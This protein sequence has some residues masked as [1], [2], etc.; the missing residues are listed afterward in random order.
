MRRTYDWEALES[1][2]MA[3]G[4][5]VTLRSLASK[6]GISLVRLSRRA[7]QGKWEFLQAR[8][9]VYMGRPQ[10]TDILERMRR[11]WDEEF[12]K[13]RKKLAAAQEREAEHES[14]N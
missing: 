4:D 9:R 2:Y 12:D 1:E 8:W 13:I 3:A 10:K 5:D 11:E 14:S 6:H 7:E